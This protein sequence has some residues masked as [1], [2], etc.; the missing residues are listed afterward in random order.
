MTDNLP[1][2]QCWAHLDAPPLQVIARFPNARGDLLTVLVSRTG[3]T[4]AL[5]AAGWAGRT[6][7]RR[8]RTINV[9]APGEHI[10]EIAHWIRSAPVEISNIG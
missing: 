8:L 10:E 3:T 4:P 5:I 7:A 2:P 9:P 1:I 6:I